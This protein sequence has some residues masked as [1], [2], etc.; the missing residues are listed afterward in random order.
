MKIT[1][2]NI[3]CLIQVLAFISLIGTFFTN[4]GLLIF[5]ENL[6]S[7]FAD[8]AMEEIFN[9]SLWVISACVLCCVA[10]IVV[11]FFSKKKF[12]WIEVVLYVATIVTILVFT[13]LCKVEIEDRMG[14]LSTFLISYLSDIGTLVILLATKLVNMFCFKKETEN[15]EK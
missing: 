8:S 15:E 7:T 6:T 14:T 2:K 4:V 1:K 5:E 9:I 12:N 3:V 10:M 13:I 11:N